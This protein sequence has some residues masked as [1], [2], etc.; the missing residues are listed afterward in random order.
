MQ[1]DLLQRLKKLYSNNHSITWRKMP[2]QPLSTHLYLPFH[3]VLSVFL[4][5]AEEVVYP[6]LCRHQEPLQHLPR[7]HLHRREVRGLDLAVGTL[8]F[9][10]GD[11]LEELFRHEIMGLLPSVFQYEPGRDALLK[12]DGRGRKGVLCHP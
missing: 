11:P 2:W 9:P 3:S 5:G 10:R 7:V 8:D 4:D 6:L 1:A 12:D